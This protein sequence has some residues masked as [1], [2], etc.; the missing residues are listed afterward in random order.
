MR[1]PSPLP[2]TCYLGLALLLSATDAHSSDAA[3]SPEFRFLQTNKLATFESELS[4]LAKLGF[5]LERLYEGMAVLFQAAVMSRPQAS[6]SRTHYEYKLLTTSRP[7]AM[8]Q[9]LNE[10]A[11]GGFRVRAVMA[12]GKL[13]GGTESVLVMERAAGQTAR[14]Y[15]YLLLAAAPGHE[16]R[17]EAGLPQALA[18]GFRPVKILKGVD[19]G[20]RTPVGASNAACTVVLEKPVAGPPPADE[21][22]YRLLETRKLSTMERE[23]NQAAKEG[24]RLHLATSLG[25]ALVVRAKG[26][27]EPRYEYKLLGTR[28]I[29]E[30]EKEWLEQSRQGF[31]YRAT[32]T[33]AGGA[34]V[35]LEREL[36]L[37][38]PPAPVEYRL[39]MLPFKDPGAEIKLRDEVSNLL[40]AGY[41]FLDLTMI[42]QTLTVRMGLAF[43]RPAAG[44]AGE[45]IR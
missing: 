45:T 9:E 1:K 39:F 15:E 25:L 43:A 17:I 35:I 36:K 7:A 37:A 24:F 34:A 21:P 16:T 13:F 19:V 14:R 5:R 29:P 3:D 10:S 41:S 23:L 22:E 20:V 38:A 27:Q 28:K 40:A 8:Q 11:G 18:S 2:L 30:M 4:T 12:A 33:G 6:E 26:H 42:N 31:R 44:P 32:T